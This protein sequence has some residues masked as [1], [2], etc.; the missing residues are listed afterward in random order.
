MI[1]KHP[2]SYKY[3]RSC[4]VEDVSPRIMRRLKFNPKV[5][6]NR[7]VNILYFK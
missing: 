2:Q 6:S 4:S 5:R 1:K 7:L 3:L